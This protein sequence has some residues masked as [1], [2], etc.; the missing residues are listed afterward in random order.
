M[1]DSEDVVC[2]PANAVKRKFAEVPHAEGQVGRGPMRA[3]ANYKVTCAERLP[4]A[5]MLGELPPYRPSRE[6]LVVY[7]D[8]VALWVLEDVQSQVA[9]H[10]CATAGEPASVW[11]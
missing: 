1:Q 4:L 2:L 3:P 8:V 10:G 5:L 9:L 11:R 6:G 7:V